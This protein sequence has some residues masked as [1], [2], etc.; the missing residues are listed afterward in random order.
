M[1][2]KYPQ[3]SEAIATLG[4]A[5]FRLGRW[6]DASRT[7][8]QA[9]ATGTLNADGAYFVAKM[10]EREGRTADAKTLLTKAL[11]TKQ[12][13]R[14][15][16]GCRA[17]ARHGW[18]PAARSPST[19]LRRQKAEPAAKAGEVTRRAACGAVLAAASF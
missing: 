19:A 1:P 14:L 5:Y 8:G 16:A 11:A 2:S 9:L 7:L 17:I 4:W 6:D 10:C 12:F 3:N 18:R 15:S 13:V